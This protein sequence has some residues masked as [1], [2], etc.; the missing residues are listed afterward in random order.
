MSVACLCGQ[1]AEEIVAGRGYKQVPAQDPD[2]AAAKRRLRG[3]TELYLYPLFRSVIINFP[4][5]IEVSI[6]RC[7]LATPFLEDSFLK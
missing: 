3:A 4:A 5:Y 2:I 1:D 6:C 7:Y